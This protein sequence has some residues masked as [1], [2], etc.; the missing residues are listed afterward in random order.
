MYNKISGGKLHERLSVQIPCKRPRFDSH[1]GRCVFN[2][3]FLFIINNLKLAYLNKFKIISINEI[4]Q[5]VG[6]FSLYYIY[7][8]MDD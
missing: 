5:N 8:G 7:A 4:T 2:V 1:I 6:C 3:Y